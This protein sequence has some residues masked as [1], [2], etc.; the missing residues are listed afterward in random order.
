M[1]HYPVFL[2]KSRIIRIAVKIRM[3]DNI[4]ITNIRIKDIRIT[5][6]IWMEI[7]LKSV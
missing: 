6:N 7:K 2:C 5:D 1:T 4:W 3:T